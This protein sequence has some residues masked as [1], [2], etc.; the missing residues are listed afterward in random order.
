VQVAITPRAA[1]GK[2]AKRAG[3]RIGSVTEVLLKGRCE[4]CE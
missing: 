3:G 2:G 1:T 4:Q